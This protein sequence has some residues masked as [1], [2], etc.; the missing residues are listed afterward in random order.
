MY[1]ELDKIPLSRFIDVYLGDLDAVV[2]GGGNYSEAEKREAATSLCSRYVR[3]VGG[4]S[5]LSQISRR[6]EVM[7]LDMRLCVLRSCRRLLAYGDEDSARDVLASLGYEPVKDRT[8][9]LR[10]LDSVESMDKYHLNKL[11]K[12][13]EEKEPGR[14]MTRE[15]FT[16][17]RVALMG[18]VR[19]YI[20]S[21]TFCAEEY[22]WMVRRMCDEI[23]AALKSRQHK[24]KKK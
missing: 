17:E 18:H 12:S 5:A 4:R 23:E 7:K 2:S 8:S 20:D 16:K 14:K 15:D 19:M 13:F 10:K 9:L 6:N 21:D 22:A 3:I 24:T 1:K 11:M